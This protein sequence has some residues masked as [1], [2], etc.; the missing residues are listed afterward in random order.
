M[1]LL[2][3]CLAPPSNAKVPKLAVKPAKKAKTIS[4]QDTTTKSKP[5]P[6]PAPSR[7]TRRSSRLR[8]Y[9]HISG[10]VGGV[11]KKRATVWLFCRPIIP[12]LLKFVSWQILVMD[13]INFWMLKKLFNFDNLENC[14]KKINFWEMVRLMSNMRATH[15]GKLIFILFIFKFLV[16][17]RGVI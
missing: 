17:S 5:D 2:F 10:G 15:V 4:K 7:N 12:I 16:Y 11:S 9:V 13:V 1:I 14:Y 3:A 8:G 6:P